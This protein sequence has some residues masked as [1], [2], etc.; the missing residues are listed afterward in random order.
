MALFQFEDLLGTRTAFG[1]HSV[2]LLSE[3]CFVLS[4]ATPQA[5]E[6]RLAPLDISVNCLQL[7]GSGIVLDSG[8]VSL[9][10]FL[11][12]PLVHFADHIV[13]ERCKASSFQTIHIG[14]LIH[15]DRFKLPNTGS[16]GVSLAAQLLQHRCELSRAGDFLLQCL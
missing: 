7:S 5:T 3:G 8:G 9:L 15:L 14:L 11:I 1:L 13:E 2:G 16:D 6:F 10:A 4:F 12:E